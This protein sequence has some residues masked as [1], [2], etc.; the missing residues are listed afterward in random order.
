MQSKKKDWLSEQYREMLAHLKRKIF[1]PCEASNF[2]GRSRTDFLHDLRLCHNCIKL[3]KHLF[4]LWTLKASDNW[5]MNCPRWNAGARQ[6]QGLASWDTGASQEQGRNRFAS[7]YKP[8]PL[9]WPTACQPSTTIFNLYWH[10]CNFYIL[11]SRTPELFSYQLALLL[12]DCLTII[13]CVTFLFRLFSSEI[14][15]HV[16]IMWF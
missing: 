11:R 3:L 7:G 13:M 4:E 15:N 14:F 2:W 5:I 9:H 16:Y 8:S 6:E 10:V 12:L 1:S